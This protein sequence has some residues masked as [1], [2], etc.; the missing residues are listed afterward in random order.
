MLEQATASLGR[1]KGFLGRDRVFWFFVATVG[2][3]SRQDLVLA[4]CSWVATV[5]LFVVTMSRQRFPYRDR[6]GSRQEVKVATE[7]G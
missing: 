6:E 3:L 5:F 7:L 2:F 4:G 1:D